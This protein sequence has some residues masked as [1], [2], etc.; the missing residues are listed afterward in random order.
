MERLVYHILFSQTVYGYNM[1]QFSDKTNFRRNSPFSFLLYYPSKMDI[2][3]KT[4]TPSTRDPRPT[5]LDPRL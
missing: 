1:F 3:K 4:S 5:T 2:S